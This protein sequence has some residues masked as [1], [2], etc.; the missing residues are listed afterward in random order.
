MGLS[1]GLA[2]CGYSPTPL[3]KPSAASSEA[4]ASSPCT[5]D[6]AK[7]LQSYAPSRAGGPTVDR[8][9]SAGVLKVGV[10]WDTYLMGSRNATT[11]SVWGFD[12]DLARAVAKSLGVRAEFHVITAADR[13]PDLED[14]TLDMVVRNMTINCDR[15]NQIAFSAEY[16]A[17]SQKVL[18]RR[19]AADDYGKH[20]PASLAGVRV[21]APVG[22]TSLDNIKKVQPKVIPVAAGT[23][24]G[25]LMDFQQGRADA[26]TGDDTVLAG[27]AAQDPYAEVPRQD[28][29]EAEPYGIGMNKDAVDLVRFVNAALEK[30][31]KSGQWQASYDR[32]LQKRLH[33]DAHPPKPLYGRS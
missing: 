25:C 14:G 24:T 30:Y 15:W 33:V 32:W 22:S 11:N 23:H 16:Y 18:V 13:I 2:A 6:P 12:I 28:P 31:E 20:G 26:I 17:A 7:D 8:I 29:L 21:C 19:D 1:S 9:Q 3:P 4:P 27:L 10:S 5:P